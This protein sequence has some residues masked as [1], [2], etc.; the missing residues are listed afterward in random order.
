VLVVWGGCGT[1][2]LGAAGPARK[3]LLVELD[4]KY[5]DVIRQ[6]WERFQA[7]VSRG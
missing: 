2:L 7:K 1:P 4:P 3:A 5:C 6:R